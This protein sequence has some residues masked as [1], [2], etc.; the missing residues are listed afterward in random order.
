[1]TLGVHGGNDTRAVDPDPD[2]NGQLVPSAAGAGEA[3]LVRPDHLIYTRNTTANRVAL[4]RK[5]A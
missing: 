4:Q 2:H 3:R 1:M 5:L